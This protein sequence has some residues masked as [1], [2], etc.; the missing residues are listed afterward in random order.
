MQK[1]LMNLQEFIFHPFMSN[2]TNW[3]WYVLKYSLWN[4]LIAVQLQFNIHILT[5]NN[6]YETVQEGYGS[7][8]CPMHVENPS[9]LAIAILFNETTQT[10]TPQ[11]FQSVLQTWHIIIPDFNLPS[12]CCNHN[13]LMTLNSLKE[14]ADIEGI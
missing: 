5:I 9:S 8:A 7:N 1:E 10:M 2:D 3:Q 13:G 6:F 4:T 12:I 11:D 14:I